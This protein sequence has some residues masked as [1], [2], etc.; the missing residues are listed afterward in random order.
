M[1]GAWQLCAASLSGYGLGKILFLIHGAKTLAF[2]NDEHYARGLSLLN[3]AFTFLAM[4]QNCG[5]T[6]H[7]YTLFVK[8]D[9]LTNKDY[10]EFCNLST[11]YS[12]EPHHSPVCLR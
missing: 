9:V 6:P 1:K 12:M 11:G 5:I 7:E 3:N 4:P 10:N 2:E 8:D